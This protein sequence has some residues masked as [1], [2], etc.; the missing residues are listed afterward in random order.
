MQ[1]KSHIRRAGHQDFAQVLELARVAAAAGDA[2]AWEGLCAATR[3]G[4]KEQEALLVETWLPE[5]SR[6]RDVF[7]CEV[8]GFAGIAGVY[9]LQPN[10]PGRCSHVAQCAYIVAPNLRCQ[11]LGKQL[12]AHSLREA[13]RLNYRGMQFDMV[14]STNVAAIKAWSSCGFKTL[15]TLP[16][17]FR[18]QEHGFVDAHVMS[19]DLLTVE[20]ID[21]NAQQLESL[22]AILTYRIGDDVHIPLHIPSIQSPAVRIATSASRLSFEVQPALPEGLE[23]CEQTCSIRGSP[24]I[25]CP[26]TTYSITTSVTNATTFQVTEVQRTSVASVQVDEHLACQIDGIIDLCDMPREPAKVGTYGDWMIWMV[27]RAWLNDPTL[28]ELSFNNMAMPAPHL[29]ERIAPKLMKAMQTNSHLE[30]LSLSNADVH[31]SS[32]FELAEALRSNCTLRTLNLEGNYLDSNCVRELALSVAATPTSCL[33]HIRFSHQRQMGA[34]FGRP[35]EEA[36]GQMMQKNETILKLGFE[37][38]DAHW[39]NLIDRALLRNNDFSRKRLNSML[40]DVEDVPSE[41]KTLRHL[42]LH[43]APSAAPSSAFLEGSDGHNLIRAYMAQNLQLPTTSQ[44]Q[45]YAKNIDATIT[46]RIAGPLIRE[47]RGLLLDGALQTEISAVDAFGVSTV[48][49]LRAWRKVD[50]HWMVDV[51]ANSGGRFTFK[52]DGGPGVFLSEAWTAWI[53]PG[54]PSRAGA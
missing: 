53:R 35:T 1:A 37:C 44:L 5:P 11:G 15:C 45:H 38:D 54:K 10:G 25:P 48:G 33:E 14:V 41:D 40:L 13:K 19:H 36:V 24:L 21:Q 7:V 31:K 47:M 49:K 28:M 4:E 12:C 30:V 18:H 34:F 9:V 6:N 23:L 26:E 17:V 52:A 22:P 39:R 3:N 20:N 46:Y 29:E 42:I 27:H 43:E 32:A 8:E 16:Q 2:F 50:E 51:W